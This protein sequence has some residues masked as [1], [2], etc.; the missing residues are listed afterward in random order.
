ML[1][2]AA[3]CHVAEV[4]VLFEHLKHDVA[5]CVNRVHSSKCHA[6]SAFNGLLREHLTWNPPHPSSRHLGRPRA[7]CYERLQNPRV[8]VSQHALSCPR[9]RSVAAEL[10]T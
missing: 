6:P 8:V 4:E 1:N 2:E 9:F 7:E 10:T 3:H 5:P